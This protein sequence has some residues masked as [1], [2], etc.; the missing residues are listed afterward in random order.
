MEVN[1]KVNLEIYDLPGAPE[2]NAA[3]KEHYKDAC[4][5]IIMASYGDKDSLEKC[6]ELLVELCDAMPKDCIIILLA[7]KE[8]L[9]DEEKQFD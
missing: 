5:A 8:D 4:A 6:E 7:N 9:E 2:Y 1:R 3:N